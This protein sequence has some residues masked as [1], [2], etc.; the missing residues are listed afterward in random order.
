[1]DDHVDE[2][3]KLSVTSSNTTELPGWEL[4]DGIVLVTT[5]LSS[6]MEMA[7]VSVVVIHADE[8]GS[9]V[10]LGSDVGIIDSGEILKDIHTH[11]TKKDQPVHMILVI[12]CVKKF[13]DQS[14]VCRECAKEQKKTKYI[15]AS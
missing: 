15:I 2:L 14:T 6:G 13:N 4:V 1:M 10:L 12:I 9:K 3:R 11:V 5:G 8:A 7:S